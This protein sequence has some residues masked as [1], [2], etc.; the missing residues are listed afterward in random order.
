M[1]RLVDGL[2]Q[3]FTNLGIVGAGYKLFFF[4]TTTTTPKT[5]YSDSDL[6]IPNPNPVVCDA[7]GRPEFDV[8]GDDLATYKMVLGKPDSVI[9]NINLVKEVD[10]INDLNTGSIVNLNPIPVAYWGSTT[11]TSSNYVLNPALVPITS[12]DDKQVFLVDFHIPCVDNPTLNIN[13]L[14]ALLLKKYNN[15]GTK[16]PIEENDLQ[17]QRY[18]ISND[19][20]DLVVLNPS[21]TPSFKKIVQ[22]VFTSSG[23]YTPTAY[24]EYCIIEAVGGGGSGGFG[25]GGA[26]S[27]SRS[28]K[29]S[30]DIGVSQ[31]VTIGSGGSSTTTGVGNA[32]GATS[33]GTLV[34]TNG[35]N[36][37][38]DVT[39]SNPAFSSALG[40]LGGAV[41][42]G[43]VVIAG[44]DGGNSANFAIAGNACNYSGHGGDSYFG[45]GARNII[46][47]GGNSSGANA[48]AKGSG[49][50]GRINGPI[51]SG[52]GATGLVII[53]EYCSF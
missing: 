13:D 20:V 3:I 32:G 14:G 18:F 51:A 4:E 26:G 12:Y 23:T 5:T 53:T 6:T 46:N 2:E 29:L 42:V 10:P 15:D 28:L 48:V 17:V 11:G 33:V 47:G 21:R 36:G 22:Q 45:G 9:G 25:G 35:G 38:E 7:S 41:G 19:G 43:D 39:V 8:W 52:A 49:G 24:M 27:Y 50:G 34:T 31:T 37:G 16:I 30:S 1:P 44:G 40:G